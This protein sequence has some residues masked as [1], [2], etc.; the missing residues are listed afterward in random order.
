M[1]TQ[2]RVIIEV[3]YFIGWQAILRQMLWDGERG[4]KEPKEKFGIVNVGNS[5]ILLANV[6]VFSL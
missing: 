4:F 1:S 2:K 5:V 6:M 3:A